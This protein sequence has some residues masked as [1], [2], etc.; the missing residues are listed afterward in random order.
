MMCCKDIHKILDGSGDRLCG[1]KEFKKKCFLDVDKPAVLV[2]G[3]PEK[4]SWGVLCA[5]ITLDVHLRDTVAGTV[6]NTESFEFQKQ[7]RY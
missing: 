1:I 7:V 6:A 2:R 4:W 3:K 5:L